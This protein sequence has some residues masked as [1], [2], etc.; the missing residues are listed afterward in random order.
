M[1][2]ISYFYIFIVS[3]KI[4]NGWQKEDIPH[5]EAQRKRV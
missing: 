3:K 1:L 5:Q 2:V 4:R